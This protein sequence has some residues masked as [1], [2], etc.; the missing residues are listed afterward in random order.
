MCRLLTE[1][2]SDETGRKPPRRKLY[3]GLFT[4][5]PLNEGLNGVNR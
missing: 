1:K 3:S 2:H 5:V 4:A